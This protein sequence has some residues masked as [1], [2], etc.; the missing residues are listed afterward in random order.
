[1]SGSPEGVATALAIARSLGAT[2]AEEVASSGGFHTPLLAGAREPLRKE[3]AEVTF[4]ESDPVVVAN[5]DA[6]HHPDPSDWPGLLSALKQL[7]LLRR[8][9][10]L[11]VQQ[12]DQGRAHPFDNRALARIKKL[13]R[14]LRYCDGR[15]LR[16]CDGFCR[17]AWYG[18][19]S[20]SKANIN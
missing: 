20:K 17:C 16:Y 12:L 4:R 7:T 1:M 18:L 19:S 9:I 8:D 5:V 14:S 11:G 3:L 15:S 13:R 2:R 10:R 6:H